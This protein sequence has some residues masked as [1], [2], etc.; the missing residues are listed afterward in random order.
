MIEDE[1]P[2]FIDLVIPCTCECYFLLFSNSLI[3]KPSE[4]NDCAIY[5]SYDPKNI[6]PTPINKECI[7]KQKQIMFCVDYTHY[8]CQKVHLKQW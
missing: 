8:K 2:T 6:F 7:Y 5:M 3:N 4:N 1:I